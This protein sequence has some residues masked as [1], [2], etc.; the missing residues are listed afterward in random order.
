MS[1][2][3]FKSNMAMEHNIPVGTLVEVK[4]DIWHSDGACS[5]VH[6][7]LWVIA[8]IRATDGT[9]LYTLGVS[10]DPE[11]NDYTNHGL[12]GGFAEKDLSKLVKNACPLCDGELRCIR[13]KHP[14]IGL[15]TMT[16]WQCR[17]CYARGSYK[18]GTLITQKPDKMRI[19]EM[20]LKLVGA[21]TPA[22]ECQ[23]D[24]IAGILLS[25]AR[26][27]TKAFWCDDYVKLDMAMRDASVALVRE[28][29]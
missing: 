1:M 28:V 9:P 26:L 4:Y 12:E 11:A 20:T 2:L 18:E 3:D 10:R 8:H 14:E 16:E 5:K 21:M 13:G 15:I 25:L 29:E 7:R 6:A 19:D 17:S 23:M 27:R 22:D 24:Y